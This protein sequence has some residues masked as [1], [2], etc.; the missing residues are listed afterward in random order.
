MKSFRI[1]EEDVDKDQR[2][3]LTIR[4]P[5]G[6]VMTLYGWKHMIGYFCGLTVSILVAG[7][8]AGALI[9]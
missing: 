6:P 2:E 7:I 4:G 1:V 3:D 9:L 8:S 5:Y